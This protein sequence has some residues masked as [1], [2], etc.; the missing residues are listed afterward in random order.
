MELSS[1]WDPRL[2]RNDHHALSTYLSTLTYGLPL[3]PRSPHA[4]ARY[5]RRLPRMA[6]PRVPRQYMALARGDHPASLV[7][8]DLLSEPPL[9]YAYDQY[10]LPG[11]QHHRLDSVVTQ[12][13]ERRRGSPNYQHTSEDW[14]DLPR[15]GL[16]WLHRLTATSSLHPRVEAPV[17]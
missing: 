3:F 15:P 7:D 14:G 16:R 9:W 13:L 11:H 10:L 4:G 5:P 2:P 8:T 17:G 6:V 1:G 12:R